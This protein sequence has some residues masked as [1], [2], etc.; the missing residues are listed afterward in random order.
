VMNLW[1]CNAEALPALPAK[2]DPH[3]GHRRPVPREKFCTGIEV[4]VLTPRETKKEQR[5]R[6][7]LDARG[8][9]LLSYRLVDLAAHILQGRE[10]AAQRS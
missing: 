2:G 9:R 10:V 7:R 5:S 3:R 6:K 4:V 1:F 8:L